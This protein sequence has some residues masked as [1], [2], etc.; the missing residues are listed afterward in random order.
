MLNFIHSHASNIPN[1]PYFFFLFS[2]FYF[3]FRLHAQTVPF[4]TTSVFQSLPKPGM[5]TL[6]QEHVKLREHFG[7]SP[8]RTC[9]PRPCRGEKSSFVQVLL[10]SLYFYF[11][12]ITLFDILI[13]I[14]IHIYMC[15][16]PLVLILFIFI[17][18]FF[19]ISSSKIF[20]VIGKF[21]LIVVHPTLF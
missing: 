12:F 2:L 9:C 19:F 4:F 17:S 15:A 14:N 20:F 3:G 5:P 13:Y 1:F 11:F 21:L 8:I 6:F 18:F 10:Y 16:N 7:T